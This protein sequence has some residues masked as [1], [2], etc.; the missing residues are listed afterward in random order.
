MPNSSKE[1]ESSI[2]AVRIGIEAEAFVGSNLGRLLERMA[3]L[4]EKSLLK[5]L[6]D[7]DA[8]EVEAGRKIRN[9][10]HVIS[11]FRNYLGE[12]INTGRNSAENIKQLDSD[13]HPTD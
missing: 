6:V 4:E 5:A 8:E 13:N 9:N 2:Q 3:D 11:M 12:I 1:M 7:S 10:L